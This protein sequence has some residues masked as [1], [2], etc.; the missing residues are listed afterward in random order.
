VYINGVF[1]PE[2]QATVSVLD[3]GFSCGDGV[4]EVT[5]TFGHKLFQ[6]NQHVTRLWRSIEYLRLK[7]AP[8]RENLISIA[9]ST[10]AY[11]E[12][13]LGMHDDFELWQIISRGHRRSGLNSSATVVA[14]CV[15]VDFRRFARRYVF[16]SVLL[17]PLVRRTPQE[18]VNAQAKL[19]NRANQLAALFEVREKNPLAIPLMLDMNGFI[20]ETHSAN[21]FFISK[22]KLHTPRIRNILDGVTRTVV[23]N[24]ARN[25]GLE[26]VEGDFSPHD[27]YAATEAFTTSTTESIVPVRSLNG[28]EFGS[29]IPGEITLK[30][31]LAWNDVV[32]V[33][34]VKQALS[35][36]D[37]VEG[38]RCKA[39]WA[40]R[41]G[42]TGTGEAVLKN[43]VAVAEEHQRPMAKIEAN[44]SGR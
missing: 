38:E 39:K 7:G 30:L 37:G 6:L 32:E 14:Y 33:D 1:L 36:L 16:G 21:F 19:T 24:L 23:I 3:W 18:C 42:Y 22:E 4:F 10:F 44:S 17:T 11:N 35:H 15:P 12:H 26:I 5:R 20:A 8:D 27:V 34:V 9:S 41:L 2:G 25:M 31:M 29:T 13:S 40:R 43:H 28:I